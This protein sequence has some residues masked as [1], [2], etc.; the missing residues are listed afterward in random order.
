MNNSAALCVL[1][2]S[3]VNAPAFNPVSTLTHSHDPT[4]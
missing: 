1:C 3:A 4:P 2:A